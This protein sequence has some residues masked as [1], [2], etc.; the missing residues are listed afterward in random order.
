MTA[1]AI[2]QPQASQS[3]CLLV[4][5]ELRDKEV[6]PA[7]QAL[8]GEARALSRRLDPC[9]PVYT[10]VLGQAAEAGAALG[11]FGADKVIQWADPPSGYRPEA[12]AGVVAQAVQ[13]HGAKWVFCGQTPLGADLAPRLAA[14]LEAG[15]ASRCLGV[16]PDG[17]GGFAALIPLHQGRLNRWLGLPDEGVKIL[18]WD[19]SALGSHQAEAGAVAEVMTIDPGAIAA[20]GQ[21]RPLRIIKGDPRNLDLEEADRLVAIGRGLIPEGLGLME[22]LA[23]LLG[24]AVGATRPVIDAGLLPFERQIGQ[25]GVSVSPR[26]LVT[27][28]V[29]GANEFTIGLTGSPL[30]IALNSDPQARIFQSADLGLLGDGHRILEAMIELLAQELPGPE[31][32]NGEEE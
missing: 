27:G 19:P 3:G 2:D 24:A 25:T 9:L 30:I 22:E 32:G 11:P 12:V 26:L 28:G 23:D 7:S 6:D 20:E 13:E 4:V 5:A 8:T 10:L 14:R 29:S 21:V 15:L 31:T 18:S 16:E 1:W 17:K